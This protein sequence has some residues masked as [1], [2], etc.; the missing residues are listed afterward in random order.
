MTWNLKDF[1]TAELRRADLAVATPDALLSAWFE[2]DAALLTPAILPVIDDA[3]LVGRPGAGV[4]AVLHRERLY[5]L[6]KLWIQTHSRDA[7]SARQP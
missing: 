3:T 6:S 5:R 2:A 7:P 1:N 4:A